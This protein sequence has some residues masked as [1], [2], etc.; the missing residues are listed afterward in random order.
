[1]KIVPQSATLLHI[2]PDAAKLME[3]AGRTCYQTSWAVKPNSAAGF[4]KMIFNRGH[5]TILEHATATFRV[6]C[7]RGVSHE[8]V[9]HRLMVYSQESTRFCNYA[10]DRFGNEIKVVIPPFENHEDEDDFLLV[11]K[12]AEAAYLRMIER[13]CPPEFARGCLPTDLKTEFVV[14]ANLREWCLFLRQR[15]YGLT[16]KPHP[17]MKEISTLIRQAL[18][19]KAPEVFTLLDNEAKKISLAEK[20]VALV[21]D[22]RDKYRA[23]PLWPRGKTLDNLAAIYDEYEETTR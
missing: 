18:M 9:R 16:G 14:T 21:K 10:G 4:V 15:Y 1:M 7:S 6:V 23:D 11:C 12:T 22:L 19:E 17:M 5:H 20:L 3:E 8:F 13:K 2:T